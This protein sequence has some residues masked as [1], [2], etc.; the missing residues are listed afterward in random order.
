MNA[1]RKW[2]LAAWIAFVV[3]FAVLSFCGSRV[4]VVALVVAG[5][6]PF[7][8]L[9]AVAFYNQRASSLDS[10]GKSPT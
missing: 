10:T 3:V 2:N 8:L 9:A 5:T 7:F 1:E 6:L 4:R